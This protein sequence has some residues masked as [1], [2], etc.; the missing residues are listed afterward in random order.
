MFGFEILPTKYMG[1]REALASAASV[2]SA[3]V[4]SP[5]DNANADT[6]DNR[7]LKNVE[8]FRAY[9][10]IPDASASLSPDLVSLEVCGSVL[11][12]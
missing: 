2:I 7:S 5:P 8:S 4:V 11:L 10:I 1:R 12:K 6:S 9:S 3:L